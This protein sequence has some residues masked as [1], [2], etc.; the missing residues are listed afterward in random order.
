[1]GRFHARTY[2]A[3]PQ[4]KLIGVYDVSSSKSQAV[5]QEFGCKAFAGIEETFQGV[6][7]VTIATPTIF[8]A[9]VAEAFLKRHIPCLIE[10]PLARDVA[11]ATGI[12][13]LARQSGTLLQVG[14][15]ERFNP[16]FRA[17]ERLQIKPAFI[18]VTRISP[19]SFRNID[20]GVVMDIM[21]HDIDIVLK[22]AAAPL[23]RCE[24]VGVSVIGGVEDLCNARLTFANG[25]VANL[26]ASR[27][28]LRSERRIRVFSPEAFVSLDYQNRTGV[29]IGR[30]GNLE[31]IR[32]A[33]ARIRAGEVTDLSQL[34]YTDLVQV[35]K[36]DIDDVE[37]LRAQLEA[38]VRS[39]QTG[40]PPAVTGE[41]GLAAVATAHK[42]LASMTE[43]T[44]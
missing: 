15:I 11:E 44:L 12:V 9:S 16:A 34:N 30:G 13:E 3:M 36:L 31:A 10:K 33:V 20:V 25:C 29:V 26:T 39:V 43:H 38:F 5:A 41:D 23:Q 21:I 1:M 18:E 24:A 35:E 42:I 32:A 19:H 8:H 6:A 28:A 37:P 4:V 40:T 27:V 2:A 14:H 17:M 7:A 22:L